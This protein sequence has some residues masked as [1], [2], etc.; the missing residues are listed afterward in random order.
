MNICFC[1]DST[2]PNSGNEL[3]DYL[4]NNLNNLIIKSNRH[5]IF[6]CIGTDRSTGDSLGPLIGYKVKELS[7]T[8][9]HIYGSLE[10]PIH[11]KNIEEVITKLYKYFENPFRIFTKD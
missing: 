8:N 4:F 6:L 2:S 9:I 1:I 11:A 5:I 7:S 3:G 10:S